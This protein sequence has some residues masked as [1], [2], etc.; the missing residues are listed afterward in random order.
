[1]NHVRPFLFAFLSAFVAAAPAAP[2]PAGHDQLREE[3]N[4]RE[5][6]AERDGARAHRK[7]LA[8]APNDAPVSRHAPV[9]DATPGP[10]A[11]AP[12][13]AAY[14]HGAGRTLAPRSRACADPRSRA[15]VSAGLLVL[16]PPAAG[17][18]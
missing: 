7:N 9:P 17:A 15:N 12:L 11:A 14:R 5:L 18:A 2:L 6:A 8:P 16:P 3:P 4:T 10:C 13:D 1:V